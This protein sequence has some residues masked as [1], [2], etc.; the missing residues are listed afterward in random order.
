MATGITPALVLNPRSLLKINEMDYSPLA[1]E[2]SI[3]LRL[4]GLQGLRYQ[5]YRIKLVNNKIQLEGFHKNRSPQ[6]ACVLGLDSEHPAVVILEEALVSPYM[7]HTIIA[8]QLTDLPVERQKQIMI[9]MSNYKAMKVIQSML[10]LRQHKAL[11]LLQMFPSKVCLSMIA[12]LPAELLSELLTEYKGNREHGLNQILPY[13]PNAVSL[14][15]INHL[16]P[17]E[18]LAYFKSLSLTTSQEFSSFSIEQIRQQL[19]S[20]DSDKRHTLLVACAPS[21][22]LELLQR[23][24]QENKKEALHKLPPERVKNI[25]IC[26]LY[27]ETSPET[28][29]QLEQS[30]WWTQECK[31]LTYDDWILFVPTEKTPSSANVVEMPC[32][33]F[34]EC[35]TLLH[36][37]N[38]EQLNAVSHCFSAEELVFIL[39]LEQHPA[40]QS[41]SEIDAPICSKLRQL[42]ILSPILLN[43]FELGGHQEGFNLATECSAEQVLLRLNQLENKALNLFLVEPRTKALFARL[44]IPAIK[45]QKDAYLLT[46]ALMTIMQKSQVEALGCLLH[47]F[48]EFLPHSALTQL[49]IEN[50]E[51]A[52][53]VSFQMKMPIHKQHALI[54]ILLSL[55]PLER[56]LDSSRYWYAKLGPIPAAYIDSMPS[57]SFELWFDAFQLFP[58]EKQLSSIRALQSDTWL[59][60]AKIIPVEQLHS[61]ID[62]DSELQTQYWLTRPNRISLAELFVTVEPQQRHALFHNISALDLAV[63]LISL[64]ANVRIEIITSSAFHTKMPQVLEQ[65]ENIDRANLLATL[66][67]NKKQIDLIA[68]LDKREFKKLAIGLATTKAKARASIICKEF[69]KYRVKKLERLSEEDTDFIKMEN[70]RHQL[71]YWL[72]KDSI[73]PPLREPNK[74]TLQIP[75]DKTIKGAFKVC[76]SFD[77]SFIKF[78]VIELNENNFPVPIDLREIEKSQSILEQL[79]TDAT[80]VRSSLPTISPGLQGQ[81]IEHVP[82]G[83]NGPHSIMIAAKGGASLAATTSP[84]KGTPMKVNISCFEQ[85]CADI[86][87]S[88]RLGYFYRDIKPDNILYA[89]YADPQRQSRYNRPQLHQ[90]DL[91]TLCWAPEAMDPTRSHQYSFPLEE[92]TGTVSHITQQLLENKQNADREGLKNADNYALLL[93]ILGS[94]DSE[95]N[96]IEKSPSQFD[97]NEHPKFAKRA[98]PGAKNAFVFG[99][100]HEDNSPEC[101]RHIIIKAV[102]KYVK[103]EHHETVIRFLTDPVKYPLRR[104]VVELM[105]WEVDDREFLE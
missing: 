99:I 8:Q 92:P 87:T 79:L 19:N 46:D 97:P 72:K 39:Q 74:V 84:V 56:R 52:L 98:M 11:E 37:T 5:K 101:N 61:W 48:M 94:V 16:S 15:F 25:L 50:V 21:L 66:Q 64:P 9:K 80:A 76:K 95:F 88:H 38:K 14:P 104:P 89:E 31:H 45:H 102:K 96:R 100:L 17:S 49:N 42:K 90:I 77:K 57:E 81:Y 54:L 35:V 12:E 71:T 27:L 43:L 60:K 10:K 2:Q 70:Q 6:P 73:F 3:E 24:S 105:D 51:C 22:A 44:L 58:R 65:W 67:Q 78:V 20:I 40:T 18:Q 55:I 85:L 26:S 32:G 103:P 7:P 59:K 63:T 41:L 4:T 53:M 29:I 93:T 82:D 91:S 28:Y 83:E 69:K 75:P 62:F 68:L 30:P 33:T 23:L 13:M 86:A 47:H 36:E 34:N 1:R